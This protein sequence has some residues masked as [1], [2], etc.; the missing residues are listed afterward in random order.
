VLQN[1]GDK[2]GLIMMGWDYSYIALVRKGNSYEL[3]QITCVDAEQKSVKNEQARIA[4]KKPKIDIKYNYQTKLEYVD[5][6]F[7]IEVKDGGICSFSYSSDGE[8]Y[9]PIGAD[10]QAK[11]GKWIGAKMGMF[12]LNKIPQTQRSW[13]D[14]DWFRVEK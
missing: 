6:F 5:F 12:I 4:F 7:C 10:F 9:Q 3:E 2:V 13:V 11:Q 1:E 14:I 8:K